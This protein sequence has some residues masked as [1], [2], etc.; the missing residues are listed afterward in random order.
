MLLFILYTL[1]IQKNN[2]LFTSN[3]KPNQDKKN[4]K[5]ESNFHTETSK[6]IIY[7]MTVHELT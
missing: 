7:G 6:Y 3:R 4:Q 5:S 1:D 2:G